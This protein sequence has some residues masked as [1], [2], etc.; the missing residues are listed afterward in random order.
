MTAA[1][2]EP[3][4]RGAARYAPRA[5]GAA[6]GAAQEREDSGEREAVRSGADAG[7]SA[8]MLLAEAAKRVNAGEVRASCKKFDLL[9]IL[10][11]W[12]MSCRQGTF[13]TFPQLSSL[14]VLP[15]CSSHTLRCCA[16]P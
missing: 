6:R 15:P 8:A 14:V 4:A 5:A 2:R 12:A 7:S 13:R 10:P 3:L 11:L 1:W 16:P 9:T